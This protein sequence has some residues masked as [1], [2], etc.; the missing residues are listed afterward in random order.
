M[1]APFEGR[2]SL[3]GWAIAAKQR[4]VLVTHDRKTI[5]MSMELNHSAQAFE[6]TTVL[7]AKL[8]EEIVGRLVGGLQPEQIILFGSYAYGEP[9]SDSVF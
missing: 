1:A 4:R 2:Q 6:P 8:L 3:E 9:N 7:S 5:T